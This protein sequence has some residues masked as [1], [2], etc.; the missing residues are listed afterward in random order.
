MPIY[1]YHCSACGHDFEVW[2]KVSDKPTKVCEKC[3]AKK[4][5]KKMSLSGFQLKG[6]G[7]YK[8]GYS[9]N[10]SAGT[11]AAAKESAPKAASKA[12]PTKSD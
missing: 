9:K 4:A 1:E 8:D 7:W 2:Q 5:E 10:A 12:S 3:G 11:S 6:S